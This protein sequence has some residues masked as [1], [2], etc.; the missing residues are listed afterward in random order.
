MHGGQIDVF[1]EG[2]GKG[3]EF[4]VHL[5]L[6]ADIGIV[7]TSIPT[8]PSRPI[9]LG[10]LRTRRILVIDDARDSV[11]VLSKLLTRMGQDVQVTQDA[12]EGLEM[13]RKQPL[14][15]II[16]DIG[17][18]KMDGYELARRLRQEPAVEKVV[19]V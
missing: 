7:T 18:P 16:S 2:P 14:D 10:Q 12:E 17:M 13:A 19:L 15:V 4:V 3:S 9:N 1:S 6:V 5:P 11:Y 8:L